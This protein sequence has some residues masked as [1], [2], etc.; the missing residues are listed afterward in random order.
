MR[1]KALIA[2]V[3][4]TAAVAWRPLESQVP[5]APSI[6]NYVLVSQKASGH[7]VRY[8]Y[9]ASLANGGT[10][11][12]SAAATASSLSPAIEVVDATL[13]F[14]AAAPGGTVAS[15]DTFAVR[16]DA[17]IAVD[18]AV[19]QGALQ[20]AITV[21]ANAAP[22]VSAG[23]DQTTI[24]GT[25]IRL[26]G[27]A[28]DD[29]QPAPATLT[30]QWSVVSGPGTVRFG[31]PRLAVTTARFNAAGVYAL[32][33]RVSDGALVGSDDVTVTVAPNQRPVAD[34]GP[35]QTTAV[36]AT[37]HLNGSASSDPDGQALAYAWSFRSRP[38][39]SAAVLDAPASVTPSFVA[40]V[41]GSY[42]V[43]LV[44]RDGSL[45]SLADRVTV[46]TAGSAPVANAGPDQTVPVGQVVVLNGS[47]S[48]DVDGN[49]LTFAWTLTTR[50]SGSAATLSSPSS[51]S[52]SFLVDTP[53]TYQAQLVVNDG[54]LSS[55]PDTVTITTV[56]SA[57]VAQAGPDQ[58]V[59]I[60]SLVTLDGAA[61]SDVD[62][63]PL[64]YAW[65]LLSVPAG[66]TAVLDNPAAPMPQFV[67]DRPGAY[68]AQLIVNDGVVNSA[69]DT[70]SVTTINTA[71]LANA[72]GDQAA[73]TGAL[74]TLDGSQSLD[75]DGDAL[76]Y[77]WSFA[78]TPSGSQA[79]L[80]GIDTAA[81]SFVLDVAGT[82]VAQLSVSD[83]TLTSAPDTVTITTAN[84]APVAYAGPDQ[85]GVPLQAT[86]VL[87]G[88]GSIDADGDPLAFAWALLSR[89][90]G[91]AI[92]L[93][94]ADTATP[95]FVPDVAG[96]Y[97]IQLIVHDGIGT[98][99][100]DTVVVSTDRPPAARAG[101]DQSVATGATVLL[102]GSTSSDPE[103]GPLTF[104][105]TF[106]SRPAGSVAAVDTPSLATAT[107]VADREGV[108]QIELTVVDQAG[109]SAADTLSVT[110]TDATPVVSVGA[111]DDAAFEAGS[112]P[113]VFTLTR[114]GDLTAGLSVTYALGGSAGAADYTVASSD[115]IMFAAGEDTATV[116]VTPIDD[117]DVEPDETV[118]LTLGGGAGYTTAAAA[119]S[120][121]IVSD[122]TYPLVTVAAADGSEFGPVPGAFTFTREGTTAAA[123]VVSFAVGGTA[124]AG[125]DFGGGIATGTAT[126]PAGGTSVT[127]LVPVFADTLDEGTETIVATLVDGAL[128]D[129]G[130]AAAATMNLVDDP[131]T[132]TVTAPVAD[133]AEGGPV[134]GSI[135]LTR[136]GAIGGDRD[137]AVSF[138]G[139]ATLDVDYTV[140]GA[141]V[142]GG[143]AGFKAIRIPAGS[144]SVTVSIVPV[145]DLAQF[146]AEEG[147][148]TVVAS[149][150]ASQATVTITDEPR[151][152]VAAP[153]DR[154]AE[155]G[156][157]PATLTVTRGA[158]AR[159]DFA[160]DTQVTFSGSATFALDYA[161]TGA[162]IVQA[163]SAGVTVR[164]PIGRTSVALVVTPAGDAAQ[165][166][167]YEGDESVIA[168][169]EDSTATVTIED[170]ELV[171]VAVADD[172]AAEGGARPGSVTVSRG[173][174]A[175]SDFVRDARVDFAGSATFGMDYLVS[176]ANVVDT[177]AGFVTLRL[178]A[179]ESTAALTI[180]PVDDLEQLGTFE[181]P[182]TVLVSAERLDNAVQIA[183]ADEPLVAVT[184][185]DAKAD[186]DRPN[187]ATLV[188]TRGAGAAD[189]FDR[190]TALTFTGSATYPDDVVVS[191]AAI[192]GS[193]PS[194]LRVRIPA[195]QTSVTLVLTAP[196]DVVQEGPEYAR[197][198]VETSVA[199][200]TIND[201][202]MV[203][204][205]ADAPVVGVGA[206]TPMLV[207]LGAPAPAGG[208]TVTVMS[209]DAGTI[210]PA[211]PGTMFIPAG[212]TTG[213]LTLNGVA[214]GLTTL[215]AEAPV[216]MDA[217]L[218]AQATNNVVSLPAT[219]NVPFGQAS[220]IPVTITREGGNLGPIVV[221]LSSSDTAI[222]AFGA[223]TITVPS[224]QL[225]VS[226]PITGTGIGSATV[227]ATAPNFVGDTSIVSTSANLDITTAA[228]TINGAFGGMLT[229]ELESPPG[230]PLAAPP[231]GV[232][233][234]LMA[235]SPACVAVT[236]S[237]VIQV[238]TTSVNAPIAYGGT[239]PLPCTTV[240]TVTG[241]AG[242]GAD[243]VS[244][245]VNP[246]PGLSLATAAAVGG[247]LQMS[248]TV[249][250]GTALHGG[251]TLRVESS[252]PTR[253]L[254]ATSDTG[255]VGAAVVDIPVADGTSLVTYWLQGLD[256]I[257]GV[258]TAAP[259]AIS[260]SA[261]GFVTGSDT[262][263]YVQP[264]FDLQN[265]PQSI[266][267]TAANVAIHARVGVPD[268][269]NTAIAQLQGRRAG[270][271]PLSVTFATSDFAV[272]ELDLNGV[273][274]GL[275][276]QI[277]EVEPGAFRTP[278]SGVGAV[279]L[280]PKTAGTATITATLLD[281]IDVGASATVMVTTWPAIS[282]SVPSR[283]GG[284]LQ[285][286]AS[287]S[288]PIAAHGGVTVRIAS[289]DA[290]RVLIACLDAGNPDCDNQ[291]G[292][293]FKDV[294]IPDGTSAVSFLVQAED[295]TA[296]SVAA[297]VT[298][299]ASIAGHVD[300]TGSLEYVQPGVDISGLSATTTST[301]PDDAFTARVGA[302]NPGYGSMAAYQARRAGAPDLLVTVRNTNTA[303]A[304]LTVD[305]V[306]ADVQIAHIPATKLE[307]P[308]SGAGS[309]QFDPVAAGTTTVTVESANV[310]SVGS[311]V[312][313][314]ISNLP[315]MT[316]GAPASVGGG[317][318]AGGNVVLGI[319]TPVA[320][321]VRVESNDPSRLKVAPNATTTG[322]EF[323]DVTVPAGNSVASYVIQAE[324]W[325]PGTSTSAPVTIS[326][327]A[328]G[329]NPASD[330]TNYVQSAVQIINVPT[331]S[332]TLSPNA[333]FA[334]RV[335][336]GTSSGLNAVQA[337]RAGASPLTVTFTN[338]TASV[339]EIDLNGG[340][341]GAQVQTAAIAAGSAQTPN[342]PGGVEFD[343]LGTGTTV[344]TA[345]IP[346]FMAGGNTATV[347]VSAPSVSVGAPASVGGGLQAAGTVVLGASQHGGVTVHLAS[348]DATR[349][350]LAATATAIGQATLDIPVANGITAANFIVQALDWDAGSSAATVTVTVTADGFVN[351]S[352]TVTYLQPALQL[353]GVPASPTAGAANSDLQ[354]RV[355]VPAT[356]GSYLGQLQARRAGAAALT[357]TFTNSNSAAAELDLNGGLSGA[358]VQTATI[359]TG[360]TQTPLNQAG[361]VEFDPTAAGTTV[362]TATIPN[363]IGAGNT[364]TATIRP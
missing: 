343:P 310:A 286:L 156:S 164:I 284:G 37:V 242:V 364:Q 231:G 27:S 136:G 88:L 129:L 277:V 338:G 114:T 91:S 295:W 210:V 289:G 339:A 127:V 116:V 150:L 180:T 280:D 134:S 222:V 63:N 303:I 38:T 15:S 102:D 125:D 204:A 19:R 269:T 68:V 266:P 313:V 318:Q 83:G 226:A 213:L 47:G 264:A 323:A 344:V 184:A 254:I 275:A 250:L 60:G 121:T 304:D 354:A 362:V 140:T 249:T 107:F 31:S 227:T 62:G 159:T 89:P 317:L 327:T 112:D 177:G 71:P 25:T 132:I 105:W 187:T 233:L 85:A 32:R 290:S 157:R 312:S 100:P 268:G 278:P 29:G 50:P 357:V 260:A 329:Y 230:T 287:L 195:G 131:P 346:G 154:G 353:V 320:L 178:A 106:A 316:P 218:L 307:T 170:E 94:A 208:V 190:D 7:R 237:A 301:S 104:S 16:A 119:A 352:D 235:G 319:A 103:G 174:G 217:A 144:A 255:G 108:Y 247:G 97:I 117:L 288:V 285:A 145:G 281:F 251:V 248:S 33:L 314:V 234:A 183:L 321:V 336:V 137:V 202:P 300:G 209:D 24:A 201:I 293:P 152:V 261:P 245:T 239:A 273:G 120:L 189:D 322:A 337:R 200:V 35:D 67:A 153:D 302:P 59:S 95:W 110:A 41:A 69:A 331:A 185:P 253:I 292:A 92:T 4:L 17:A 191:G 203:L 349:I 5:S 77:L 176:G 225:S 146:A 341:N 72:G 271:S 182:E 18:S 197:A 246:G 326:F 101:V 12:S 21:N 212:D 224:G 199:Q 66:S 78:T 2:L 252:D 342:G 30:Y 330:T 113:G 147:A 158:N 53:G 232:A 221:S 45:S 43:S 358:Q 139:S 42:V 65:A 193:V 79:S 118:T 356:G 8:T 332:T 216:Y 64:A 51:V 257:P 192:V 335:G 173:P 81:A 311:P 169:A 223:A 61:S 188:L 73:H 40:D 96:D 228:M 13:T 296:S 39:G 361:G 98:S 151:V 206:H 305:G 272:A 23:P 167:S 126:I 46:S 279:E 325:V 348:S 282:V 196:G 3:T 123:L 256:W 171:V 240:L 363:F 350:I 1:Q 124:T 99:A 44:V 52:P 265:A 87:S 55:A 74:V 215:R 109:I 263:N 11:I 128:Y 194:G 75:P 309:L 298:V 172:Q 54:A 229:I 6:G 20:W 14:G 291:A 163:S 324:D 165:L 258:S 133:A 219:E 359:A 115:T 10:A 166:A 175:Q 220:T 306:A 84:V 58:F 155:G 149:V 297:T 294:S 205:L 70:V 333:D 122:D 161:V 211:A 26:T 82:Y 135:A 198:H 142:L 355:G 22:V 299:T 241:P 143:G 179:D 49:P 93:D 244:V 360:Q 207:T 347:T 238:G 334:A 111:T 267:S 56:N 340:L 345:T 48:S 236:P 270:A 34:A 328:V 262:T 138:T 86:V 130:A 90:A 9:R 243:T 351:A 162:D 181:G 141:P 186:E 283:L 259:V 36:G 160:R 148:E 28:S 214:T 80:A 315:S 308:T 57:P 276:A 76:T 168:T 274:G